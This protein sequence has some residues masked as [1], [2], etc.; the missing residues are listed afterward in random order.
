MQSNVQNISE[1]S[2]L[3]Y[4]KKC[5]S[6]NNAKQRT[7]YIGNFQFISYELNRTSA[8]RLTN[9]DAHVT[10]SALWPLWA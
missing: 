4:W 5:K 1:I 2:N 3:L 10:T 9:H 7:K 6:F 8:I